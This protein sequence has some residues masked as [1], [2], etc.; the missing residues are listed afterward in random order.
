[1]AKFDKILFFEKEYE[2]ELK[3]K[4]QINNSFT[5]TLTL[6]TINVTIFSYFLINTPL[7][8][9]FTFEHK[10]ASSLFP[11]F[12][13][14]YFLYLILSFMSLF[15]FFLHKKEYMKIPYSDTL[16]EYFTNLE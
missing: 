8:Y 7:S 16:N 15:E 13:Y 1:M 10:M 14:C 3:I 4:E 11:F 12:V 5:A 2:S 6:L 9:L